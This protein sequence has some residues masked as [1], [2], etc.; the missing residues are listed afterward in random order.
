M[1]DKQ[2]RNLIQK[3]TQDARN[4]L[5]SEFGEQLEGVFD[6]LPNGRIAPEPGKHLNPGQC[7]IRKKL[8]AAI[9]HEKA[10][11]V[12][13]AEAVSNYLREASFTCLNR[14]AA[15]KMLEARGL[16]QECVSKGE[17]SSG[18]KEFCGLAPGLL[19]LPDK[20][21]RLYIESLFDELSTEIR[22]L[23]D[24]RDLASLLWPG[25]KAF[26]GL[27]DI[28]NREEIAG[29]WGE[30]ETIGWVYQYF[31]SG[32]ERKKMRDA[33]AAPRN[34]RELA[35]RNQFFTPRYVVE[36]LTDNT[37]GR[38][39]YEMRQGDTV[40]KDECRYLVRRPNEV[41]LGPG[42][43]AP[44]EDDG[45]TDLSQEE[46]LKKTVYIEHRPK[47]DPRDI[48]IL[49]PACGS[50]HFLLYAFDLLE[51]IYEESWGDKELPQPEAT[52]RMLRE[53]YQTLENLRCH[54][55]KLIIEHNLHGI[56]IDH[57]AV[58]IAALSLWMRAQ[59]SW[60]R[61]SLNPHERS[62]INKSNVVTAE[63]M[64]GEE[65]MRRDFTAG[66]KPR[67]LGQLV[68]EIFEKMKL[69]GEAGAL[70]KIEEE[71]KDAVAE[72][73]RQWLEVPE[74]EQ[75]LLFPGV[76]A[77]KP[78]QLEFR[79]DVESVKEESFWNQAEERIL[80]VLKD[81][82]ERAENGH[83]IR[84]HL[85]AEDAA[86]GFAFI[87]LRLK[88]YDVVLMNPPFGEATSLGKAYIDGLCKRSSNDMFQT[89]VETM[90]SLTWEGGRVG[91]L[92]ARTGFFLGNS[93]NWRRDVVFRNRLTCFVD[94]GLG[95]LDAALV[96]VAS[97]IIEHGEPDSR[98][99]FVN[100]Q[101]STRDKEPGLIDSIRR[102]ETELNADTFIVEQGI[103]SKVP[104]CVFAYWAPTHFL[105][106]YES[107]GL[108]GEVVS[109]VHPGLCTGNDFRFVR[110]GWEAPSTNLGRGYRWQ[111][112]SKGGEYSPFFDDIHLA[113]DMI[114]KSGAHYYGIPGARF[115]NIRYYY[116]QGATYTVRTASAFAAKVLPMD[117]IFSHNAQSWF[118]NS[119]DRCLLSIAF[120]SC[121]VP[122]VFLELAVGSGDIATA[123]SAARRYTTAV[124]ESVPAD[125]I[126]QIN[127]TRNKEL[128]HLLFTNRIKEFA[129]LET[130]CLFVR[131]FTGYKATGL[132]ESALHATIAMFDEI[133]FALKWS[134]ELDD[135]VS[136]AFRMN[137]EEVSFVDAEIGP[138]P[139]CYTNSPG[140]REVH[141]LLSCSIEELMRFSVEGQGS[142]R[143]FTK[144]SYFVDRRIEIV[145]HILESSPK[146]IVD[147]AKKQRIVSNLRGFAESV[148]SE[149][150]GMLMGR[151]DLRFALDPSLVPKLPAPFDPLPV[152]P[153][154]M[155]ISPN[156][157]PAQPNQI[158]SEE[159]LRARPDANTLPPDGSVQNPTIPDSEYPIRISWDSILV[160][161][162]GFNNDQLHHEDI[163]R[164]IR[165]VLTVLWKDK[166]QDIE[167]EA[168]DILGIPD[169]R[170]YFRKN[171]FPD[172][173]K[174]Y[175]KSRRK[176]PI[177]WQLSTPS[178]SYSIWLYY[179][180]FTKDTF[181]Q[182]LNEFVTPKLQFEE[183]ELTSARQ[184]YGANPTAT[185]RKEIAAR[186]TFVAE[187]KTFKEEVARIAPL[188]NP[189]L[190]DG[191]I[192]NFAPLW[193]LVPQNRSW[194]KECKK[195]WDKLVKGDYDW[196]HLAM[197]LWPE[198]VVPKCTTDRSLAIAHELD[199]ILWEEDEKGKRN[200]KD[201]SRETLENLIQE[202][203][204]I[205]VKA[206]LEDLLKAPVPTGATRKKRKRKT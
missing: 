111:R 40:L 150:I 201:I 148:F 63:P 57:R 158:V 20:G 19:E 71:I 36:F 12:S 135:E 82:A 154:G 24:R 73:K 123:G 4:L 121:R 203:T 56:D 64:P 101:L 99:I 161:D 202:R 196:A 93:E 117:C 156:G 1:M 107:T 53:D 22:V 54:I 176:A 33:S 164:R 39:W 68:D 205:T 46:L 43:K 179:H 100:R 72:A 183:R 60:K 42:E 143:W 91:V 192:I 44:A 67:V 122:Q 78:R 58:Q 126:D 169:L 155:L 90:L 34:S 204:S 167:Q 103:I 182:I 62:Q 132:H 177:Y 191:V 70:L 10:G 85:F 170:T 142:K 171:F 8:I 114:R 193:R 131:L 37:L 151:W 105:N 113:V 51:R 7:I 168:C 120:L 75:Q 11:G 106:R 147:A 9:E 80:K 125:P 21:Y 160:D 48:K 140:E 52:G 104:G 195:V 110:L 172:H 119:S 180:R 128:A 138:H 124:V 188:W 137:D 95:V 130:S 189:N 112:F 3:A 32:E 26:D 27:L 25:R 92:S 65:D 88:R 178:A 55:P 129:R 47:K 200:P 152:C 185:Q 175:S 31:N 5:E 145:S 96:E 77:R 206:A 6:I 16:V 136:K 13:D 38:I 84:R 118:V 59:R 197:H 66:L 116:L 157:L 89:F 17:Q 109:K 190:N 159:W 165:E 153:P 86:R 41:F 83:T 199:E 81:Y 108:F 94:L 49:D 14:F 29:V 133:L 174:R 144:K 127:T 79:F 134:K 76:V 186:E 35:V 146:G 162:P 18:F 30:D 69:A 50:G 23:F 194:Q 2:T 102:I 97:Y 163:I 45:D 181:Y 187:L 184:Q 28:L 173:I 198:R 149:C 141:R 98:G 61:M 115:Q 15:L 166:A 87:S 139:W 74:P